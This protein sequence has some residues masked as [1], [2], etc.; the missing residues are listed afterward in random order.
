[1]FDSK[2]KAVATSIFLKSF[3]VFENQNVNPVYKKYQTAIFNKEST[4][5]S[6]INSVIFFNIYIIIFL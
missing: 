5:F 1:M 6:I 3:S 4:E 2:G